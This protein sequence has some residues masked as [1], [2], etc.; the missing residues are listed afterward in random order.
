MILVW[1]DYYVNFRLCTDKNTRYGNLA[2]AIGQKDNLF[3][4]TD[5]AKN[6]GHL[7]INKRFKKGKGLTM[8]ILI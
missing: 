6:P 1:A 3:L 5:A 7:E 8:S 4:I 2:E